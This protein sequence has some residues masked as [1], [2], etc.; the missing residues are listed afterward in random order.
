MEYRGFIIEKETDP[1]ALK[2]GCYYRFQI[3]GDEVLHSA[4]SEG[5]AKDQ[6]DELVNVR[7]AKQLHPCGQ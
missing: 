6:I 1:W 7:E 3:A 2:F 4:S 5:D